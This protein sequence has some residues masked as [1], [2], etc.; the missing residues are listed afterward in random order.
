M[1][2]VVTGSSIS[3]PSH[4]AWRCFLA[5]GLPLRCFGRVEPTREDDS[6]EVRLTAGDRDRAV[7]FRVSVGQNTGAST[8][9][10][11]EA[12]IER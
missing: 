11:G 7:P 8:A 6:E 12:Y 9:T 5:R 4:P 10:V 1:S 3:S 2:K